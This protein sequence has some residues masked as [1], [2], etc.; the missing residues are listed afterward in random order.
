MAKLK[1]PLFSLGASGSIGEAIVYFGWKGLNVAREYV[2]PANPKTTPQ[3]TQRGYLSD[4]VAYI[5]TIQASAV[6]P[7]VAIDIAA[8]AL[9][10][11]TY[12]T[13]RTWFNQIIKNWLDQKVAGLLPVA[14][15]TAV[16]T[17]AATLIK[18]ELHLSAPAGA[19]VTADVHWGTSKTAL[20][21]KQTV[22]LANLTAGINITGMPK[23]TKI[24]LQVRPLDPVTM[25]GSYSGI[26]YEKTLAA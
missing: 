6:H 7:L 5:H 18:L 20:I 3:K 12:P 21:N 1:G 23:S 14:Y 16:L 4:A 11:S 2:V 10:G 22:T 25:K 8:Y 26:Y 19:L 9:W 13:P 17:P 15:R 24:F